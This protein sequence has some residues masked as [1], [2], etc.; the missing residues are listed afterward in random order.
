MKARDK[1]RR[2]E[3]LGVVSQIVPQAMHG[4]ASSEFSM[5]P[6]SWASFVA[7]ELTGA[8]TA[9]AAARNHGIDP[10][11]IRQQIADSVPEILPAFDALEEAEP[12]I[13]VHP[14]GTRQ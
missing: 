8:L 1:G 12:P 14:K 7:C 13:Q 5:M 2:R 10:T 11:D 9:L 6:D 4:I 3:V